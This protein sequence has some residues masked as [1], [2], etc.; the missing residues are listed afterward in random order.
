[1]DFV[2]S[3][4]DIRRHFGVPVAGLVTKVDTSLQ[5]IAHAYM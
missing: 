4:K 3:A 1:M 5:H 2:A